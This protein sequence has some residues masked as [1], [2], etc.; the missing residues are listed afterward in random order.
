MTNLGASSRSRSRSRAR[1]SL[2]LALL[3]LATGASSLVLT[4]CG[5]REDFWN[6][7]SDVSQVWGFPDAVVVL[8]RTA[9]RVGIFKVD[10]DLALHE[11][12]VPLTE[13]VVTSA[14][15]PPD[16]KGHRHLLLVTTS[17][18]ATSKDTVATS[19]A[20]LIVLDPD[21][22]SEKVVLPL[23]RAFRGLSVDPQGAWAVLYAGDNTDSAFVVN[24]NELTLVQLDASTLEPGELQVQPHTLR[25][26]GGTPRRFTFTDTLQLPGGA[27]RLLAVETDKDVALINLDRPTEADLTIQLT[28]GVDTRSLSPAGLSVS[29]GAPEAHDDARLAIRLKDDASIILV[30]LGPSAGRDYGATINVVDVGGAPTDIAFVHTDGGALAL[31]ALV[32]SRNVAVVVDPVTSVGVDV[33]LPAAYQHLSLV[34]AAVNG[35]AGPQDPDVALLWSEGNASVSFWALGRTVGKPYRSLEN[36]ALTTP[37]AAVID[38]PAPHLDRKLLAGRSS[39][40]FLLDLTARTVDPFVAASSGTELRTGG[41]GLWAWAFIPGSTSLAR[42]DLATKHPDLISLEEPASSVFE[43]AT[44]STGGG[45]A[46]ALVVLHQ[47]GDLSATVFN[48]AAQGEELALRRESSGLLLRGRP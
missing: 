30:Q 24:P 1:A 4:A 15:A 47:R 37:L 28:N 8:D 22:P 36:V 9:S 32:P 48:A 43:V 5:E 13:Q 34:T 41:A 18:S 12:F 35:S 40:F 31:A 27:R 16:A 2:S 38:L 23:S 25:S 7:A 21:A 33:A 26:F 14:V 20:H 45:A 46:H 44:T 29:D 3:A 6:H 17:A 42:L 10:G 39:G 11:E 19:S